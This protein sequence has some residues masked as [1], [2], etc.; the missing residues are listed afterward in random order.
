VLNLDTSRVLWL[1]SPGPCFVATVAFG[2]GAW[3]LGVLRAFRDQRLLPNAPGRQL[4]ASYYRHG[5]A[6]A[7]W[8]SVR[9]V[10]RAGTR[11]ALDLVAR[12]HPEV[13]VLDLGLPDI[14]G[15]SVLTQARERGVHVPILVLT[16]RDA[17]KSRVT[18]LDLGADDYLVKPFQYDELLARLRALIRRASAPRWAP[19]SAKSSRARRPR[20]RSCA[21][22]AT[23]RLRWAAARRVRPRNWT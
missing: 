9:P 4:V 13:V 11:K 3:Q 15:L 2:E 23:W 5:P 14:D 20:R 8:V 12:F 22:R 17:V 10:V 1:P 6:L 7:R 21:E 18:A 19:W 16:A